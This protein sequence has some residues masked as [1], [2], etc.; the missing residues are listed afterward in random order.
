MARNSLWCANAGALDRKGLLRHQ[1]GESIGRGD[2]QRSVCA[3]A[4]H[5]ER[6]RSSQNVSD[7]VVTRRSLERGRNAFERIAMSQ[8]DKLLDELDKIRARREEARELSDMASGNTAAG[9]EFRKSLA[10][11]TEE[12]TALAP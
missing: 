2:R 7:E 6:G 4:W 8:F 12:L 10:A 9:R 1:A 11:V 3:P 5:H